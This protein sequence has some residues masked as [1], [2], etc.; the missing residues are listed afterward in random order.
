MKTHKLHYRTFFLSLALSLF[1][2]L[3]VK[4]VDYEQLAEERKSL[5]IESN[6]YENWP[7]GPAI[8]AQAAILM[9]ANTGSILYAKNIHEKLYPAS[10]TKLLTTYIA[11][12][13]CDLEE[14]VAFSEEAIQSIHWWEDANMGVNAGA[15]LPME[16]VLYGILVGSANEAAYAV[17]EH[18]S[19]NIQDF[20]VLMNQT[21]KELGCTDSHFVTPNGIHDENHYTTAYD[22]AL[23]AKAFFANDTLTKMSSTTRYEVPVTQTQKREGIILTA[24]SQLHPGKTYAYESLVGTKTGYTDQARQTLVSCAEKNGL[25]LICVILKEEAPAQFTDTI[26]LFDYGFDNFE[27]LHLDE[28]DSKYAIDNHFFITNNDLLGSSKTIL[29]INKDSYIVL[30]NTL[31]F[32]EL[33]SQVSY[34]DKSSS[35]V[36]SVNYYYKGHMLG[37]ILI[38]LA[39]NEPA[40]FDFGNQK[41]NTLQI[42]ETETQNTIFINVIHFLIGF[43]L[44]TIILT[45]LFSIFSLS[46]HKR[47]AKRRKNKFRK[48]ITNGRHWDIHRF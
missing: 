39:S 36:A 9:D 25:K 8:G 28:V 7:L 19:G 1:C 3:P 4:A 31:S 35:S 21:A 6:T 12:Q 40:T 20:A 41:N 37:K 26:E 43:I 27:A 47:M 34:D 11:L 33:T 15:V 46:K 16:D 5:E 38:E 13:Q 22:M 30:P 10:I 48:N 23:I 29:S 14:S 42:V 2:S 17:A 24:K 45:A 18:I 44:I 32:E